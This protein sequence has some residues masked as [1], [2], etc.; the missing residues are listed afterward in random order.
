MSFAAPIDPRPDASR[1]L[2]QTADRLGGLI[3][4][5]KGNQL[6]SQAL[7]DRVEAALAEVAELM[8]PGTCGRPRTVE[9]NCYLPEGHGDMHI[10][11]TAPA[12]G[13]AQVF[14]KDEEP[15]GRAQCASRYQT[16]VLDLVACCQREPGHEG[17]HATTIPD[18]VAEGMGMCGPG[19]WQW[20]TGDEVAE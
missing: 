9:L 5:L 8:K 17:L 11:L 12:D 2:K 7:L 20:R 6:N 4:D 18:P 1:T 16:G 10:A 13:P 14:W 19:R 3:A 15:P